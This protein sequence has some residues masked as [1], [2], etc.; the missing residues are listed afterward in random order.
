MS[1]VAT[2]SF[3]TEN[4][5]PQLL[6]SAGSVRGIPVIRVNF[7]K[8][9]MGKHHSSK[10]FSRTS[11]VGGGIGR[12]EFIG[13]SALLLAGGIASTAGAELRGGAGSELKLATLDGDTV[14]LDR[15][16]L[17]ELRRGLKG[18]VLIDGMPEYEAAR[19]IWNAAIDRRP[20]VS[21]RC[22]DVHD[23][24]RA[25]RFA[26]RHNA[27]TSVRAGGHNATGFAICDGGVVI[28]LTR[29][30]HVVVDPSKRTA[31]VGG[32]ATFA[33]FDSATDGFGLAST[34]PVVSMVGVG[35]FTLGG[36]M[37][38]LHRKMGLAC[39]NLVSARVVTA[40]G[41]VVQTSKTRHADLFWAIR[42]GGGN[43]GVVSEFEF[44]V[45][46]I[47][48]VLA[49]LI[50]HP[51]ED[52]PR[53]AARVRD[54][55]ANAPDDVCVWLTMRKAPASPTLPTEL[56]G[57][58]VATLGVCYAGSKEEGEKVLRPLREFGRP[59]L[60]QVKGRRYADWQKALDPAWGNGFGNQWVGHYLPEFTDASA[61]T[62]L[63]HVSKVTSPFTDVKL[64]T[65]GG[66]VARVG[67]DETA[68]SYRNSK[69]ALV[70]QT[71]WKNPTEPA[72]HLAWSG[73]F[74]A[75]MKT[76]STGKVYV[77]FI[78]DEGASRVMDAYTSS[79]FRRLQTIK[80]VYDPHN[81]LRMNQNI[82]P[83]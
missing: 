74:F 44:R 51:L 60:D 47:P 53:I 62:I 81:R 45:A 13:T 48:N 38:W 40:N 15:S 80:A 3:D 6:T 37:G 30:S 63:E 22:A 24:V 71:R 1:W 39:D 68:F 33:D 21:V 43:F 11:A 49:G 35:G 55:N 2:V 83:V 23:I 14:S 46:S 52:L 75:A 57:R 70:I 16:A 25:V 29:M 79:T 41:K 69:Y 17:Q 10:G 76:H 61:Q 8:A 72:E 5:S 32:G 18:G 9:T 82:P 59:L 56:H 65:L 31:I 42:G 36:G 19:Q 34:G 28:D 66:A 4:G 26:E 58:P 77:N 7:A 67:E 54:F 50:F 73:K 12:R 20:S 78:A 27:R 64:I